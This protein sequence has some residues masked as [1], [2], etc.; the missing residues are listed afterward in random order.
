M[1]NNKKSEK[2]M[3]MK[4]F[5]LLQVVVLTLLGLVNAQW[6]KAQNVTIKATNGSMIAAVPEGESEYDTFL[7]VADLLLGNTNS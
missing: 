4:R 5:K 3:K 2:V 6:A 1:K 7:N